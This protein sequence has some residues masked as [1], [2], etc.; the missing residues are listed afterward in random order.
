M[1][2]E[3]KFKTLYEAFRANVD[4]VPDNAFLCVPAGLD[5][6]PDGL[7]LTYAETAREVAGL[8]QVYRQAGFRPGHRVA[9]LLESRPIHFMHFLALNGLGVSQVPI[10]PDLQPGELQHQLAH[11]E[12]DL[13]VC[14]NAHLRKAHA[15]AD[16]LKVPVVDAESV[17]FAVPHVTSTRPPIDANGSAEAALLYTSGTTGKP[18]A[19]VI[20][21]Y[22]LLHMGQR[23]L[24]TGLNPSSVVTYEIG[25]ERMMHHLPVHHLAGGGQPFATTMMIR[26]CLILSGRFSARRW[27]QDVVSTRATILFYM[28]MVPMAL[29]NQ[30]VCVEETQHKV[31]IGLGVGIDPAKH[32][33]FERRFGF[34]HV[35][36]W[37]MTEISGGMTLHEEPRRVGE[38]AMG[39]LNEELEARI[40]DD[41]DN[42][43][44]PG[45]PGQLLVRSADADPRKIFFAGY[46]KDEDAT[47]EAWK[48]GWFHTGDVVRMEPDGV[49]FFVD[50]L[51]NIIRRSGENIAAAEVESAL[52][53]DAAIEIA[54][55]IAVPDALRGEEVYA[56]VVL[57]D[58]KD[59]TLAEQ[60]VFAEQ[61]FERCAERLSYHKVPG[62]MRFVS[63][64][65][66][67]ATEKVK[68]ND[69]FSAGVDPRTV[70]DVFDLRHLKSKSQRKAI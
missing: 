10:N 56:C 43:V 25:K 36:G 69:L 67:T 30:P 8:M 31:K 38:R 60:M 45:M 23:N 11:S 41:K 62:W 20:S 63:A 19:C 22:F 70:H 65:P 27:W 5:Y 42:D 33:E 68:R 17:P 32:A 24:V 7:E 59:M 3:V 50:R 16:A 54:A 48:D 51:K 49:F 21:N 52:A 4:E 29:M 61:L 28:G 12:C 57:K 64:L 44:S 39:R 13:M 46:L 14:L 55:V 2:V 9:L 34:P 35:E 66:K 1:I 6:C 15:G 18:K 26:G 47:E 53:M 37:G 58:Q 40:V